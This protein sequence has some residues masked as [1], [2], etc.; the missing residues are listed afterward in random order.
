VASVVE[1]RQSERI[2]IDAPRLEALFR[3]MGDRAAEG[4]VMDSI[5]DISDRLA[6]IELATR[7]G[8]LDDVPVKAERVVSLCNGIGLISLARVTGDLG[9]AAVRG[10]MIAYRAVWERLV[11]IGD[12][13]LAQVWELPGLSL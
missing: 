13:S 7:I 3:Q 8:A 11:R 4:F 10:D 5:E 2:Q 6:E 9:A 12:R 1:L